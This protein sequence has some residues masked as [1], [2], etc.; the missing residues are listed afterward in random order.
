MA[1]QVIKLPV[2][3]VLDGV[4]ED[5]K[6]TVR[7]VIYVLHA[8]KWCSS[9][10]VTPSAQGYEILAPLDTKK[11]VDI[12]LKDLELIQKVD[13]LR[14]RHIGLKNMASSAGVPSV[15]IRILRKGEP[16]VLEE[17]DILRVQKRKRF[18]G[19]F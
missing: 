19:M 6:A 18:W 14:V 17:H 3:P 15:W 7:D 4:A 12:E 8:F 5:D 11:D 2:E 13:L 16:V 9:W 1:S 10:S